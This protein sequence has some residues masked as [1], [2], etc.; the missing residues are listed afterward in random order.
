MR[1]VFLLLSA[2]FTINAQAE[3][4]FFSQLES[5]TYSEPVSIDAA[6]NELQ[7]NFSA[8][9][10]AFTHNQLTLGLRRGN[11]SFSWLA[12]YDY[13]LS[14]HPDTAEL[15][16]LGEND[17]PVQLDRTYQLDIE[18]NRLK[19]QGLKLA[20]T[21]EPSP[22]FTTEL[23]VSYLRTTN[24]LDGKMRGSITT[25]NNGSYNGNAQVNYV[26]DEDLFLERP[27]SAPSGQGIAVDLGLLWQIN[28]QWLAGLQI[29][30]LYSYIRW[31]NAPYTRAIVTS[32]VVTL[33]ENGFID[34]QPV[35]SGTEGFT[36]HIQR[37]PV[38][39]TIWTSWQWHQQS[40]VGM[41]LF[42]VDQLHF[43][44]VRIGHAISDTQQIQTVW[45]FKAQALGLSYRDQDL[46][47]SLMSDSLNFSDAHTLGINLSWSLPLNW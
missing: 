24:L 4:R 36:T 26:Y 5:F 33:D 9:E 40:S 3:N 30:D 18:A 16:Y 22:T 46:Q 12:R 25:L 29:Q 2:L 23:A 39:S 37:L 19:A 27:V 43:P 28:K 45:D 10:E 32:S 6:L 21:F 38:R 14:F 1:P 35:L 31:K 7:G 47:L 17:L 11:W 41:E 44:R 34:S 15:L 8:G 20:Y 13:Y 42:S